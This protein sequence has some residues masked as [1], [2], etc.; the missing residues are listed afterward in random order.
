MRNS[1]TTKCW[2]IYFFNALCQNSQAQAANYP[3]C[4][5]NHNKVSVF[6]PDERLN[7]IVKIAKFSSTEQAKIKYMDSAEFI[8]GAS[9]GEECKNKFLSHISQMDL[10]IHLITYFKDSCITHV[11]REIISYFRNR[12][13]KN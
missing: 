6:V 4:R 9:K 7:K 5:T 11:K 13:Y 12:Y 1:G 2:K 3:F 10:T 8:K